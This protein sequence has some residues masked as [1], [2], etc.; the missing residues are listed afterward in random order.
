[1]LTKSRAVRACLVAALG[2]TVGCDLLDG[3][4]DPPKGGDVRYDEPGTQVGKL[5][6]PASELAARAALDAKLAPLASLTTEQLAAERALP[7]A[8]SLGFDP[9]TAQNLDLIQAST[10]AL[11]DRELDKLRQQGFVIAPRHKFPHMAYGY[12]TIYGL[13]LPVY[14]SLDAILDTVHLSYDA[15]LKGVESTYLT[16]ELERMLTGARER[17]AAGAV[18]DAGAAKDLDLF[19]T[20]ALSLLKDHA[21]APVAGASASEVEALVA[22]GKKGQGIRPIELFGSKRDYDFS[23][24]KPRGHYTDSPA[25]ERYFRASM[26]LGRT[27]FRLIETQPDGTQLFRRRQLEAAVA[28]RDVVQGAAREAFE[29]VDAVIGAFVGEHDSMQLADVDALLADLGASDAKGLAA[30]D[31]AAIARTIVEKGYGAQRIAS[32]VIYKDALESGELPLDRSFTLL[33]QRYTVDS[34][35]FSNVVYDR[36]KP[37]DGRPRTL[38]VGLDAAYGAFGN[39]AALGLLVP[40]L[41]RYRYAPELE[42]VRTLVDAH[43]EAYWSENLYNLWVSSLR[44]ISPGRRSLN[45]P[46][47]YGMPLVTGTEA[48]QRRLL[49]TQLASWAE[50]RHDTILYVKQS[51]TSG[52]ACE[53][54]DGYVDPYPEAFERLRLYALKGAEVMALV[55][56]EGPSSVGG[57]AQAYFAELATVA[58][59]L[60]DMAQH[61]RTGQPFDEAQMAFLNDAVKSQGQ[62]CGGP[63]SYT[64]WFG[65]LLFDR[66]DEDMD[67]T[68][69]DVHTDPGGDRPPQVLHVGTGLPRLM[70]V[71]ANTC[72]GVRAYAGL[73][74]AYHEVVTGLDRLTDETWAKQAKDADDVAFVKPILP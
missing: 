29:H 62:G 48:W 64:G 25:L 3:S 22:A 51:Y 4:G 2:L 73:A 61:E 74:S 40:E 44:A 15:I 53:F 72:E 54:P 26:W 55:P 23:Q 68:I 13:D 14:V 7:Y 46:A 33:G 43:E 70:V 39:D 36:V 59:T 56:D 8:T 37:V 27:D 67:P 32:Q 71:T 9:L 66:S 63:V 21:V 65:R 28:L 12:R 6:P 38:P 17:L 60:R 31:D 42:R 1:M 5:T 24:M 19:L 49:N 41:E 52:V 18:A 30:H 47:A 45:D 10:L 69:A 58:A 35:V 50:L 16:G 11:D 20:V 34:H 57:R